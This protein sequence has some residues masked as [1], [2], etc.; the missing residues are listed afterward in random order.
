MATIEVSDTGIGIPTGE[1]AQLFQRFFRSS[2]AIAQA[3]PGTGLGLY[4]TNAIAE[5]H[6]GR[7]EFES[8]DG[9]GTVFRI[10]LP[11]GPASVPRVGDGA[12]GPTTRARLREVPRT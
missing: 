3:I 6:S 7:I 2:N 4:I 10:V 8:S 1:Q 5:A 9:D 11:A 12:A